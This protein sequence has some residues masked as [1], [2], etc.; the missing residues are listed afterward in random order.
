MNLQQVGNI[1]NSVAAAPTPL[2][3]TEC[4]CTDYGNALRLNH[5]F[6]TRAMY[7]PDLKSW[8]IWDGKCWKLD[9]NNQIITLS[10]EA[11]KK[12]RT[13]E[14][15]QLRSD[16]KE[17]KTVYSWMSWSL[18][19]PKLNGMVQLAQM[20]MAPKAPLDSNKYLLNVQNGTIDL[21]T[22]DLL[23]HNKNHYIT[24]LA[25]VTYDSDADCP[26][27]H[28]FLDKA[29]NGDEEMIRYFQKMMGYSLTADTTEK[30]FFIFW[31][32]DGN[33]GKTMTINIIRGLLGSDYCVQ[34]ASESLMSKK[35]PH[36]RSDI[37]RLKGFRF[38]SA[39]ETDQQYTFNEALVKVLTGGDTIT[40]RKLYKN[41]VEFTPEFKLFIATNPK[42]AFNTRDKALMDR[43]VIIPFMV[44]IPREEMNK[45][46]TRELIDEEGAGILAWA[47][48]G[49]VAWSSEGLGPK[50]EVAEVDVP[51]VASLNIDGFISSC[52][53]V[54]EGLQISSCELFTRYIEYH[55]ETT[56]AESLMPEADFYNE[57]TDRGFESMHSRY[58]NVRIGISVK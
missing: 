39:S 32:P 19:K 15:P 29:F 34:I 36:I 45:N 48:R 51:T 55:I 33:N 58:G 30:C 12:I 18:N 8:Y 21:R 9:N 47:V 43:V 16:E 24:K 56:P 25:P 26:R 42:P 50:P 23:A 41:E 3:E 7:C 20:L 5:H 10:V 4:R 11:I 31:G 53:V 22:G 54:G 2:I 57:I 1:G 14:L 37:A 6:S 44:P 27:W 38:A 40:A 46:L 49:A 17:Y 28:A 13:V 35:S 52:C